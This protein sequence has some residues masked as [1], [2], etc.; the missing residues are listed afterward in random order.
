MFM[1]CSTP[2]PVR[3]KGGG[4]VGE[5]VPRHL[6][7]ILFCKR[8]LIH[9]YSVS[10]GPPVV[11]CVIVL[12]YMDLAKNILFRRIVNESDSQHVYGHSSGCGL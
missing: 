5:R 11:F 7:H 12:A 1:V 9:K 10:I 8:H 6:A 4:T 2:P 3:A